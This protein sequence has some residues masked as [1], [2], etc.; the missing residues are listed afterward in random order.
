MKNTA[1]MAPLAG[2]DMQNY[3]NVELNLKKILSE[4]FRYTQQSYLGTIKYNLGTRVVF[5]H[6]TWLPLN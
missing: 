2:N 3:Y 1:W 4:A 5:V 6:V